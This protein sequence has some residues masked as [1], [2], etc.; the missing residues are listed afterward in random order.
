MKSHAHVVVI[1]GGVV[2]CSVLYHLTKRGWSDCLL[3]ERSE[4]TSGST[5]HAAGG[6]HTI[7]GDPNVAKL[8]AYT[9]KLYKE[10]EGISGQSCGVHVT[11]GLM[12]AGSR[13]RMDFLELSVAKG[14]YQG[15]DLRLVD[16]DEAQEICPLIDK[17]Q[18][19]GAVWNPDEGHLDPSGTTH[20]YAKAAQ[21]Q[22]A[23]IS[24]RNRVIDINPRTD[25]YWD[26]VTEQGVVT[27]EHVVNAGGL[28]AREVGHMIGVNLPLL[29]MEHM[30]LL[31]E[32]MPEVA[33]IN[34]T[35]GKEVV[36]LI[37]FEGELYL[38]QERGGMLMGTY[39]KAGKPW[40]LNTTPWNFGHELLQ[41]DVD[42]IAPSL[43]VGFKH[44][45]AFEDAG[46]RQI[47]NG[48]FTFSPDGNPLVGKV[49]GLRGMWSAC[50]VMAGFS[51]GGGVGL[52][53]SNWMVDGDPG[54]DIFGMDIARFGSWAGRAYTE[55]KVRE[56]YAN[57]FSIRF[58]NEE[59]EAA[60]PLLTTPIYD[61][62]KA[63][64]AVYGAASGL[65]T[66]LWFAP[67][68]TDPVDIFSFRRSNSF[69]P[70]AK[71]CKAVRE[72]AGLAEIS[73]FAKY[74]V[75]G[76]GAFD[77]LNRVLAGRLPKAGRLTLCPML[78]HQGNLIGDFTVARL[79]KT[80]SAP[81]RYYIFGSGLAEPSHMRW[82]DEQCSEGG[83]DVHI[84]SLGLEMVGLSLAGPK[85]RNILEAVA[86]YDFS[87]DAF[88]FMSFAEIDI[89]F[90]HCCVGRISFT[91]G[92]GYELWCSPAYQRV[93]F[94]KIM[95]AGAEEGLQLFGSRA[96][97]A[98]SLEKGYG[99]WATEYRPIYTPWQ[100]GL[101]A[102][103]ALNKSN[104]IGR[105]AA[106]QAHNDTPSHILTTLVIT[107]MDADVMGDEP[108][109]IGS[110]CV[111]WVTSG[112]YCH[113][114]GKSVALA[115]IATDCVH[116]DADCEVHVLT[117]RRIAKMSLQPLWDPTGKEMRA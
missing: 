76:A 99:S 110:R 89:G 93:L 4:L 29:A 90:A 109:Y 57:R 45:P 15:L 107:A 85:A 23:E 82:F 40:S 3:I 51:Q 53:L 24:L 16:L 117:E 59:L 48:P 31:T 71:E 98:L 18:F 77:F 5:W 49:P 27:C 112:G 2:G 104:F 26:V 10:I 55:A 116:E 62:L 84:K 66:P 111:G 102:F 94:N 68:G 43:E 108:V 1:G 36:H 70:I 32:D 28:W 56:N 63:H 19:V 9:I 7:N 39:E 86:G 65:E 35:T 114:I 21:K 6:F 75:S 46:I 33:E 44:F 8:Q 61:L 67:E 47:I 92:L 58:P 60:R 50:A 79:A 101:E 38:R 69:D 97:R 20:A 72:A 83:G 37:D 115:Y 73:G 103:I 80:Q 30:Y 54:F 13:E 88:P 106:S 14:D 25:G 105:D 11:G 78:N 42:R 96:M 113:H 12:L 95:E 87:S 52:A 34:R 81:E 64:G 17:S 91:G 22:G 41:P 74:E 100:A